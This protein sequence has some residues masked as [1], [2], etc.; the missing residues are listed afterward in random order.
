MA[1]K[2]STHETLEKSIGGIFETAY[3]RPASPAE[4]ELA[5][6]FLD[7]LMAKSTNLAKEAS[8]PKVEE[9][10]R[11]YLALSQN[12]TIRIFKGDNLELGNSW[13]IEAIARLNRIH[14]N[15]HVN[16]LLSQ[17]A[18]NHQKQGWSFGVTSAKSAYEPR[19]FIMQLTGENV[20]G[21]VVYR[22]IDSNLRLPL[23]TEL[24]LACSVHLSSDGNSTALFAW[25]NLD[26]PQ[27]V[28]Q[29]ASVEHEVATLSPDLKDGQ[30]LGGRSNGQHFWNG[31][32]KRL[33]VSS[34][35]IGK[36]PRIFNEPNHEEG[37]VSAQLDLDLS[38]NPEEVLEK[39]GFRL[40]SSGAKDAPS[41][42][43]EALTALCHAVLTSNEFL[44]LH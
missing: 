40:L 6:S 32:L 9:E 3:G 33:R 44:Y 30:F 8:S 26:A 21:D 28:L 14:P 12:E 29:E 36:E 23:E 7:Q 13:T 39:K 16:T 41:P 19:N 5:R 2:F 17:S 27:A 31:T 43:L 35:A 15:A 1:K 42:R 22:V 4:I 34:P 25:K 10:R 11:D 38:S 24:Y 37:K 18:W 20:G